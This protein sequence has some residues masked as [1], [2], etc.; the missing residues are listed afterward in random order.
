MILMGHYDVLER[1]REKQRL[2]DEDDRD[3]RAGVASVGDLAQSNG[4]FRVSRYRADVLH[5][6]APSVSDG[7]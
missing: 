3:L 6:A 4:F 7:H 5:A 1:Q 2:R